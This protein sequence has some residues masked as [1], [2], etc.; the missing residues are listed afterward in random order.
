MHNFV[1]SED[2]STLITE[3][4][5]FGVAFT[6]AHFERYRQLADTKKIA[7][8]TLA[9]VNKVFFQLSVSDAKE[10]AVEFSEKPP[11]EYRRERAIIISKQPV[12]DLLNIGHVNPRVQELA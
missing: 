12:W 10:V 11:V 2:I 7:G 5:K 1:S 3:G 4:R 9:T 8:A 6:G